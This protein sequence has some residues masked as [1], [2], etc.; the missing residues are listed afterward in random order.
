MRRLLL[1]A[2]LLLGSWVVPAAA[3][4]FTDS[5][6]RTVTVP[7]TV[8]H[9]LAAGPPAAVAIYTVAP[10]KLLGWA[11]PLTPEQ[12]AFIAAPFRDRPVTGRLTGKEAS[13]GAAEVKKLHPDLIIDV[14]DLAPQYAAL[15]DKIQRE[16]GI[17]YV[18]LDGSI[19]NMPQLFNQLTKL[20]GSGALSELLAVQTAATLGHIAGTKASAT[21]PGRIYYAQRLQGPEGGSAMPGMRDLDPQVLEA[22]GAVVMVDHHAIPPA[23]AADWNPDIVLAANAEIAQQLR[24]DPKW[25]QV[26]AVAAGKIYVVPSLPFGWLGSPPGVNRLLGLEWL[27]ALLYP[28]LP[29]LDFAAETSAFYRSYYHVDLTD[30]QLRRLLEPQQGSQ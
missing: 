19:E 12:Q 13:I 7:D 9:V 5:L 29:K 30:A 21:R 14:G 18:V 16:T 4:E 2:F 1:A 24:A 15:A 26:P 6:G 22:L 3:L 28:S 11:K 8:E 27:S 10:E 17:P 20:L 25:Q 23:Q